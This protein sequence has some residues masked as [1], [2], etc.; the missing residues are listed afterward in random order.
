M[1][2]GLPLIKLKVYTGR[3][4]RRLVKH[5]PHEV[6]RTWGYAPAADRKQQP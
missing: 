2:S 5:K 4:G 3:R 1:A 6:R